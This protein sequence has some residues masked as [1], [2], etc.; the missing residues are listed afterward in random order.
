MSV[1]AHV[2]TTSERPVG[3]VRRLVRSLRPVAVLLRPFRGWVA[4]AVGVNVAIHLLTIASAAAGAALVGRAATGA[5]S[6]QLWPLV[7]VI[8]ALLIPLGIFG[9]LDTLVTHVMS[10]RLLH[11]L[12]LQLYD[13]FRELAPAYLLEPAFG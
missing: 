6:H 11:D 9:W 5:S 1:A 8:V 3:S 2:P 12:R 10:F 4:G 13:R 7:W